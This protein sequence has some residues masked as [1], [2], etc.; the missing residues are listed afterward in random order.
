MTK[1]KETWQQVTR[2]LNAGFEEEAIKLA[3]RLVLGKQGGTPEAYP[4]LLRLH[5]I[6]KARGIRPDSDFDNLPPPPN[7][8][9]FQSGADLAQ[10]HLKAALRHREIRQL[11]FKAVGNGSVRA[12]PGTPAYRNKARALRAQ[13]V[14]EARAWAQWRAQEALG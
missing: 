13:Q 8:R 1:V 9:R 5:P 4:V 12:E 6:L 3:R 7:T 10:T 11:V 14:A 2:L